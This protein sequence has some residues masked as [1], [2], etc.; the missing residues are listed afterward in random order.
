MIMDSSMSAYVSVSF[1]F[2]KEK[3]EKTG[4]LVERENRL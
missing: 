1:H 4:R 2:R 3:I